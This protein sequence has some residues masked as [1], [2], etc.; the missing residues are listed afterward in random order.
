MPQATLSRRLKKLNIAKVSGI[1]QIIKQSTLNPIIKITEVSPNLL[2]INTIPGNA[3]SVAYIIDDEFVSDQ[4]YGI[5]GSIAGD[6]TIFVA[7][8]PKQFDV[9]VEQLKKF[10]QKDI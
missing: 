2:I 8:N 3:N 9:A 10:F 1:Y 5:L 4:L 6:D 7:V